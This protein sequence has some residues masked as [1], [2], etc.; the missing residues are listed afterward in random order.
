M[1]TTQQ[2][3][4]FN[5]I[6]YAHWQD[7]ANK[8]FTNIETNENLGWVYAKYNNSASLTAICTNGRIEFN[9]GDYIKQIFGENLDVNKPL[10]KVN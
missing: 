2:I 8:T 4:S 10:F 5:E 3:L 6:V 9:N 7:L 1:S